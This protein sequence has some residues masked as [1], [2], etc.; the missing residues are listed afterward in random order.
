[1]GQLKRN[2]LRALPIFAL[3]LAVAYYWL[4]Y[5]NRM[6]QAGTFP[7]NISEIHA[8]ATKIAGPRATSIQIE[9][10]SHTFEPKMALVAGTEWKNMDMIRA[11]YRVVFPDQSIIIDTGYDAAGAR[12]TRAASYILRL[13]PECNPPCWL[14][15]RLW[16]RM[17]MVIISAGY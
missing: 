8:E 10:L 5:D 14:L 13:G 1:M 15:Q 12:A 7:L 4:F 3:V 2:T 11:S 6:P 17:S 9:T 16:L